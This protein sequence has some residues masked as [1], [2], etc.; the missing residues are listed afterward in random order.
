M[1][2]AFV[3]AG[4]EERQLRLL[5]QLLLGISTQQQAGLYG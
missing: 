5:H 1:T 2:A 4:S 3:G